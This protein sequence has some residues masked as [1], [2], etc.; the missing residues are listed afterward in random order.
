MVVCVGGVCWWDVV[1]VR[2]GVGGWCVLVGCVGG[3][4]C[5]WWDVLV[6]GGVGGM[7]C[8]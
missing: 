3:V 7:L 8:W 1:L 4:G 5:W 2:W 6:V